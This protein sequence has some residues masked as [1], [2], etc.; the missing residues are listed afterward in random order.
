M[1]DLNIIK[2]YKWQAGFKHDKDFYR[3]GK[4]CGIVAYRKEVNMPKQN[5]SSR[6]MRHSLIKHPR[7]TEEH[8]MSERRLAG[9]ILLSRK[10]AP[11]QYVVMAESLK[12]VT[13]IWLM[14]FCGL[15]RYRW[16]LSCSECFSRR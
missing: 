15:F 11:V 6:N 14:F 9:N 13:G 4:G 10:A 1:K 7:L 2:G 8:R 16:R 3:R 5:L 12:G